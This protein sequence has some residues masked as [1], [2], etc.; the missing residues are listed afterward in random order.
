MLPATDSLA[1]IGKV[2]G[3]TGPT[4]I[5]RNRE[6]VSSAVNS[7][8]QMNDSVVTA[9]SN[10]EITFNDNTKVQVTEQSKLVIDA[11]VYDPNKSDAGRL[12]IRVAIGTAR[13]ASGQIAKNNPQN[14]KV[15]TP[16]AT[17][18]VRGTDF[19][20]TV[21][22]LGRSLIILLPSCPVGWRNIQRDCKTGRIDVTTE[23]GTVTLDKAFQST[24]TES[25]ESNPARPVTLQL[26]LDQIN[27]LL[28]LTKPK[29]ADVEER[30]KTA[31]DIN[32]LDRNLLAF[33]D[34]D[35]NL[36]TK[37]GNRLDINFLDAD[38]LYNMI[39]LAN[40]TLLASMFDP[41][42][43]MLPNYKANRIAGLR[44]YTENNNLTMYRTGISSFAQVTVDKDVSTTVNLHQ[45]QTT[46]Q[47]IVNRSGGSNIT[48]TQS[49]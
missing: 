12:G 37:D 1:N 24:K 27:N 10:T 21:D 17:I 45:D 3:Q 41:E 20:M 6:V 5:Q 40:A 39:D 2:T 8:V 13:M 25:R 34:L 9:K 30:S 43:Q 26:S 44:Y 22:E 35:Q 48:I 49:R 46:I 11:F 29:R 33:G 15:E 23:M 28:I 14:V 18:A 7:S 4:E 16:T 19:S 32:F 31:L 47:Q 36:L 42:N 38:F